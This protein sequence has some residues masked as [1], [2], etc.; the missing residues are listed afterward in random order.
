MRTYHYFSGLGNV[1]DRVT[2]TTAQ[3]QRVLFERGYNPGTIDNQ[4]GPNTH[5]ALI[6]ASV[7][8]AVQGVPGEVYT[9]PTSR[10]PYPTSVVMDR[11]LWEAIRALPVTRRAP[12]SAGADTP[13]TPSGGGGGGT[14]IGPSLDTPALSF[15]EGNGAAESSKIN[16]PVVIGA[17]AIA[18]GLGW[19]F[20]NKRGRGRRG[21]SGFGRA[22]RRR[23]RSRR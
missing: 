21:V 8:L 9:Q 1:E 19:F 3:V 6:D 2:K 13:T 23:R 18:F 10:R 11:A 15:D 12:G 7:H 17:G 14:S 20:L 22:R 5:E 4:Y 16:W